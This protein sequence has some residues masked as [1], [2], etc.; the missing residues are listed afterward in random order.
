LPESSPSEAARELF[1]E[2]LSDSQVH[3][4]VRVLV[5]DLHDAGSREDAPRR[6]AHSYVTDT[7]LF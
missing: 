5:C 6:Q 4:H 1:G 2:I 3:L 7:G